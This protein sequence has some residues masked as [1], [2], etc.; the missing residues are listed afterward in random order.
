MKRKTKREDGPSVVGLRRK[1][2]SG[3]KK[4]RERSA[5]RRAAPAFGGDDYPVTI[6]KG[7]ANKMPGTDKTATACLSQFIT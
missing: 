3:A 1:K 5:A 7:H 2:R 6:I 4:E